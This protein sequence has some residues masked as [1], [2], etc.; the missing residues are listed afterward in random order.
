MKIRLVGAE[1]FHQD[2]RKDAF[3]NFPNAHKSSDM[4]GATYHWWGNQNCVQKFG[5][6]T[7]S[8]RLRYNNNVTTN[9]KETVQEKMDRFCLT[10]YSSPRSCTELL[11]S[12]KE[13]ELLG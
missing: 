10:Y 6:K 3:L 12:K 9:I 13:E 8:L 11:S 5:I 1:L 4:S 2:R 7:L